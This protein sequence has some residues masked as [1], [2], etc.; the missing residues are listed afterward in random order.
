[1][2]LN[3][4]ICFKISF[5]RTKIKL[6]NTFFGED[7]EEICIDCDLEVLF[8]TYLL[9]SSYITKALR[10]LGF[11]TINTKYFK[12]ELCLKMLYTSLVRPILKYS[13][14]IWN[15]LQIGLIEALEQAQRIYLCL[16]DFKRNTYF[17]INPP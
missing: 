11:L 4:S 8:Q 12:N 16:I 3:T 5:F 9:L 14:V 13:L 10:C 17:N 6:D 7:I 2:Q 1:M 15:A